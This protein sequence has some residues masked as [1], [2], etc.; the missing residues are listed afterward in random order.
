[1]AHNDILKR[2]SCGQSWSKEGY[3]PHQHPPSACALWH[4]LPA[5]A[6]DIDPPCSPPAL[7]LCPQVLPD[8]QSWLDVDRWWCRDIIWKHVNPHV[9]GALMREDSKNTSKDRSLSRSSMSKE[10]SHQKAPAWFSPFP[11]LESDM[12]LD[13]TQ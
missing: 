9:Q 13:F 3:M 1:M 5:M 12:K 10:S 7:G 4:I 6:R 2:T 8:R 11:A